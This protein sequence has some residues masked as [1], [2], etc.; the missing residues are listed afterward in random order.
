MN[1]HEACIGSAKRVAQWNCRSSTFRRSIVVTGA[2]I[3]PK[4]KNRLL[5]SEADAMN[6]SHMALEL[7]DT[8]KD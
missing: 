8:A 1:T 7:H 4:P 2:K 5:S 6:S 3:A